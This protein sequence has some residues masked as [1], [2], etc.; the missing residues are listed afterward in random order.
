MLV[1]IFGILHHGAL[2]PA[3]RACRQAREFFIT[4]LRR[5]RR[6]L[7]PAGRRGSSSHRAAA[8][9]PSAGLQAW[10]FFITVLRRPRP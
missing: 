8:S 7:W 5:R 6:R 3:P 9:V 1:L 2:G 4:V 10:E